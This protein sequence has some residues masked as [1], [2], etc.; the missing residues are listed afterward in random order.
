MKNNMT[1]KNLKK[2]YNYTKPFKKFLFI[3]VL[4]VPILSAISIIV[5]IFTAKQLIYINDSL[6]KQLFNATL[7]ILIIELCRNIARY[8]AHQS[9]MIYFRESMRILKMSALKAVLNI[10][11]K[12]LDSISS[13][14]IIDRVNK[15]CNRLADIIPN[16]VDNLL[17]IITNFGVIFTIFFINKILFVFLLAGSIIVFIFKKARISKWFEFDKKMRKQSEKVTSFISELI[18][19][20]RDIKVLNA[21]ENFL[22]EA[23]KRINEHNELAYVGR[24]SLRRFDLVT[25][26][27]QD[28]LNFTFV[29][30]GIVLLKNELV[31]ISG[32][33]TI[34]LY[35]D[36]IYNM[37]NFYTVL[38]E[39]FQDFN[40]SSHRVF[41]II[42]GESYE[43][44]T[45]GKKVLKKAY[46]DFEF[47]NVNFGYKENIPVLKNVN[48][49][50][51]ANSTVAFVGKSGTG[52]TTIFSLL[53]KLYEPDSGVITIDNIDINEL[54]EDSIRGNMTIINQA[55][56][57]FNMSIYDNLKLVNPKATKKEIREACKLACLEDYINTL[58]DKYDTI[59]GEGGITLS[60]GQKQR[61]AIAR[62]LI[63]KTEII[64][65]DEATSALDNETQDLIQ[66][67]IN[68]M[69]S[70]YTILIIAHRFSTVINSDKIIYMEDGTIK[71]E[72]THE[73]LLKKSKGYKKLYEL[74]LKNK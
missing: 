13:G 7:L 21:N 18:R 20:I 28:L 33:V 24:R 23:E 27:I 50:V 29:V 52:K 22:N 70:E 51:N 63:Q 47:K 8:F 64:L 55:P 65:F 59:V 73:E 12:S 36:R 41:E 14:V 49:K 61:L 4:F 17:N 39:S 34:Y 68:N 1:I 15:D 26:S 62:A 31:T 58:P 53:A 25:G 43:R 46:G 2:V 5:P 71:A 6:F 10:K 56:Y 38:Q 30:L 42:D 67:A 72:G 60:G 11:N 45:F 37:F 35:K 74:E 48:F 54:T 3:Y 19:G 32:F 9:L 16:I 69:K 66:E 57:I 40:L 44:E